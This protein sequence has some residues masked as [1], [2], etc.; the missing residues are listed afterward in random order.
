MNQVDPDYQRDKRVEPEYEF[1][2]RK[3]TGITAKRGPYEDP[4]TGF[5]DGSYS[6]VTNLPGD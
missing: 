6:G 3:F 4:K 5:L 1:S 2:G